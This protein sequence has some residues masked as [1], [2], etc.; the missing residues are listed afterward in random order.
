M[1][2]SKS[3]FIR[4]DKEMQ[5]LLADL[6]VQVAKNIKSPEAMQ[7]LYAKMNISLSVEESQTLYKFMTT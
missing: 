5:L 3:D 7:S 6:M 4:N 1:L 2:S